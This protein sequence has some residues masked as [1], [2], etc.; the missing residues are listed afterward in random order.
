MQKLEFSIPYLAGGDIKHL[1]LTGTRPGGTVIAFWGLMKLL[2]RE[3]FRNIV[4]ECWEN[5]LYLEKRIEEIDGMECA[6]K[7]QM[8]ILGIKAT[9]DLSDSICRIDD[10]LRKMGWALGVFKKLNL[11]RVVIMPHIKRNHLDDFC[12]DLEHAVKILEN[13]Y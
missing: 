10:Q 2:G 1:S 5:T 4:K 8:N 6:H 11:A 3:G 7:P 12:S 13:K 9:N